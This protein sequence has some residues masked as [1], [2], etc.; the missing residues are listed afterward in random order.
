MTKD[1]NFKNFIVNFAKILCL[2]VLCVVFSFIFV[3]PLCKWCELS[4]KSYSLAILILAL[5]FIIFSYV[6]SIVKKG[7]FN[8]AK[9]FVP[10]FELIV[11]ISLS[12][13]LIVNF[14]II[15][16]LLIFLAAWILFA[17]IITIFNKRAKLNK[18]N[19]N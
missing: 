1:S 11:L 14:K 7:I 19:E 13:V 2:L 3:F 18:K 16:G 10:I 15:W 4:P 17:M 12:L 5:S 8:F 6:K 9:V